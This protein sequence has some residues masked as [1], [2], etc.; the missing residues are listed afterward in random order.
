MI[1]PPG[2][3]DWDGVVALEQ[4]DPDR[5]LMKL[6]LT[7]DIIADG[8]DADEIVPFGDGAADRQYWEAF[9]DLAE[10]DPDYDSVLGF[11]GELDDGELCHLMLTNPDSDFEAALAQDF[12][13]NF[14][15]EK[16]WIYGITNVNQGGLEDEKRA[17]PSDQNEMCLY[18]RPGSDTGQYI[19]INQSSGNSFNCFCRF[20]SNTPR[21]P[22]YEKGE[23]DGD[24]LTVSGLGIGS[25]NGTMGMVHDPIYQ[26]GT[27][28]QVNIWVKGTGSNRSVIMAVDG[29]ILMASTTTT[30]LTDMVERWCIG[31]GFLSPGVHKG[32]SARM[33]NFTIVKGAPVI[34]RHPKVNSILF[35]GDSMRDGSADRTS[36]WNTI[37]YFRKVFQQLTGYDLGTLS[38]SEKGGAPLDGT[39]DSYLGDAELNG[40]LN[41]CPQVVVIG[42]PTNNSRDTRW[43][44]GTTTAE[45]DFDILKSRIDVIAAD[46]NVKAIVVIELQSLRGAANA[47]AGQFNATARAQ[48]DLWNNTYLPTLPDYNSKVSVAK[49]PA[50]LTDDDTSAVPS[51]FTVF[52][53]EADGTLNELHYTAYGAM[54]DAHA[55]CEEVVNR[56]NAL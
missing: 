49:L 5:V 10:G 30:S 18:L 29:Q 26:S 55:I 45:A 35:L 51:G 17:R 40:G 21:Y 33:R 25:V 46:P 27:H 34:Q 19:W 50:M 31:G 11:K 36:S 38:I 48:R 8:D 44:D 16:G 1:T 9:G 32:C 37:N 3:Y 13:I 52:Q 28:N 15:I 22:Y 47:A 53:G 7:H 2:F 24:A 43:A 56:I 39:S 6:K 23:Y 4:T 41:H 14:E 12:M 42:G 54:Y 20:A